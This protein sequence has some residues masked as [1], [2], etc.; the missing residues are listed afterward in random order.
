MTAWPECSR[1]LKSHKIDEFHCGAEAIDAWSPNAYRAQQSRV[2]SVWVHADAEQKILGLF[3]LT[4]HVT[5]ELPHEDSGGVAI[6]PATLIGKL[7]IAKELQGGQ[8]YGDL[9]LV[10]AIRH[11]VLGSNYSASRVIVLS[12]THPK[13]KDWYLEH[14]FLEVS[15][16]SMDLYMKM[17]TAEKML[18]RLGVDQ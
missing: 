12:A 11:A 16:G 14:D 18:K 10:S 9:L 13:V 15:G 4:S 7:A 1:L 17:S 8:G 3:T 2:S 5:S 6:S